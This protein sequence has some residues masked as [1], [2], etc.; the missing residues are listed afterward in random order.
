MTFFILTIDRRG[1]HAAANGGISL[2]K[3]TL[4]R[5]SCNVR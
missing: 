5:G 1:A 4:I 3:I 2:M